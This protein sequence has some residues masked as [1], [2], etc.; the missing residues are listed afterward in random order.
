MRE[1][2]EL[3]VNDIEDYS[4]I[5]Y[6]AYPSFKDFSEE[7]LK[8]Y[9]E[10]IED[11]MKNDRGVH[12]YGMYEGNEIL[13]V[14][15]LFDFDMNCFGKLVPASGLGYLGVDLFHKKEKIA[16]EM[17]KFYE[18]LY[19][20]KK[21]PIA[22]LL[23]FRP[24][25]Y[26]PMGYGIGTKIN[27]YKIS[28][29]FI[30]DYKL[31]S[32]LKYVES[33][34]DFQKVFDCHEEVVESTHGMIK[35]I[36][37]EKSSLI[38]DPN[39]QVLASFDEENQVDGY[40]AIEF[41]N[42]KEDNLFQNNIYVLEFKYKNPRAMEKLLSFLSRQKDEIQ[43]VIFNTK[44]ENFHY[45]FDNPLNNSNNYIRYG[46]IESNTQAVGMMYKVLDVYEAFR[47]VSHRNFNYLNLG[48]KF[49]LV[50]DYSLKKE[51]YI[52]NF[53]G[54]FVNLESKNVDLEV[55]LKLSDF[56]S[57]FMGAVGFRGLYNLG[58]VKLSNPDYLNMLDLGFYCEKPKCNID[59]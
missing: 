36:Y 30:K 52:V 29:K 14:M 4:K 54:G 18:D 37:D 6:M 19:R 26:K 7:G 35:K 33:A 25:F 50:D 51:E 49:I 17:V 28:P 58:L 43:L 13:A 44:D 31:D 22:S 39:I 12:F 2:R 11:S 20:A 56:S 3:T 23:P 47:Q 21:A 41:Q 10:A 40:M 9:Y 38:N 45:L 24:D 34:E 27:Q 1:I 53:E 57:L 16:L 42:S 55:E 32:R 5:A 46:N 59:F 15:R 8:S 48:L